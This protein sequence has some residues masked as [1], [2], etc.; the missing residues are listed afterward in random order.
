MLR[1]VIEWYLFFRLD[2]I[3]VMNSKMRPLWLVYGTEDLP[4]PTISII[5]KNGD[6]KYNKVLQTYN[7]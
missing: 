1:E 7:C 3:K 4:D 2:K 5:Y 6:G